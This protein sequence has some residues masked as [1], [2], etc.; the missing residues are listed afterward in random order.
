MNPLPPKITKSSLSLETVTYNIRNESTCATSYENK[1]NCTEI[2]LD[3]DHLNGGLN[4]PETMT[5]T[6][7]SVNKD[8]IYAIGVEDYLWFNSPS[9]RD[10]ISK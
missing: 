8:Y 6:N 3:V 5:L 9:N 7:P 4:G 2:N 10:S 1:N